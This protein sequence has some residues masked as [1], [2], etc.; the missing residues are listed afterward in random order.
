M[1]TLIIENRSGEIVDEHSFD[2]GEFI[3]G[4]SQ[5]CDI[6]LASPNV[7]RR[8]ARLFIEG[9][10]AFLEDLGSANGAIVEGERIHGVMEL[11]HSAQVRIGDY[12]LHL[13]GTPYKNE[14]NSSVYGNLTLMTSDGPGRVFTIQRSNVLIGRGR[15]AAI[16]ILD[17]SI[18]RIHVKLTVDV[19][20]RVVVEDL[21][22]A[23]G[24]FINDEPIHKGELRNRDLLRL[25]HQTLLFELPNSADEPDFV[26]PSP[27]RDFF[28]RFGSWTTIARDPKKLSIFVAI[29][30]ACAVAGLVA[31]TGTNTN[32]Q[33][34]TITPPTLP[35]P[36]R[37]AP[38]TPARAVDN[39]KELLEKCIQAGRRAYR[40]NDLDGLA[41][42]VQ[43]CQDIDPVNGTVVSLK[44]RLTL[45][46]RWQKRYTNAE[47]ALKEGRPGTAL[48]VLKGISPES[49][50]YADAVELKEAA[51]TAIE[52]ANV[53]FRKTCSRNKRASE[54]CAFQLEELLKARPL[55]ASLLKIQKRWKL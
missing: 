19:G 8:H 55:D 26:A 27:G 5:H 43:R 47:A 23:N 13:E 9:G 29:V 53:N 21:Q 4:R 1:Y 24:T 30:T 18:S 22:S 50:I 48:S 36:Q 52:S 17:P 41:E 35:P 14:S 20:G 6:I 7:S 10:A 2:D 12:I 34:A 39:E 42:A 49:N 31:A 33:Q 40:D 32:P 16:T 25:G 51:N 46:R 37:P 15:D 11:G 54:D 38:A 28:G 44:N 3:V 45:E